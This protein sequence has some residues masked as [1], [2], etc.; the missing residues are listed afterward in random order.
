[1]ALTATG[2]PGTSDQVGDALAAAMMGPRFRVGG[3]NDLTPTPS[4]TTPLTV[5][6][7]AGRAM[8]C[9]ESAAQAT[10]S[11]VLVAPNTSGANRVDAVVLRFGWGSPNLTIVV[12]PGNSPTTPPVLTWNP[13]VEYDALLGYVIVRNGATFI[14]AADVIDQRVYGGIGGDFRSPATS[15]NTAG[16]NQFV[17]LPAGA[18]LRYADGQ[19]FNYA[20]YGAALTAANP[21]TG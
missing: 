7:G 4:T 6:I 12:L 16:L 1:M 20:G 14:A 21:A 13:G 5:N 17:D 15:L 2:M 11:T 10:P 8:C 19:R 9:G 18:V 3:P